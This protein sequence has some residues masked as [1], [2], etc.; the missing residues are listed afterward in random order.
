VNKIM[1]ELQLLSTHM[2]ESAFCNIWFGANPHGIYGA[3]PTD[4]MHA[5]LHNIVPYMVKI[6]LVH[7]QMQKSICWIT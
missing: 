4:L 5:F 7:S 6:I 3:T 2:H 1:S